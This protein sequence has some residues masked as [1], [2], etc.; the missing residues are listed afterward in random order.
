MIHERHGVSYNDLAKWGGFSGCLPVARRVLGRNADLRP[1]T[2]RLTLRLEDPLADFLGASLQTGGEIVLQV[3]DF[4][5]A[6]IIEHLQL[7]QP[8]FA[9]TAAYGHFGRELPDFTWE[10]T[11]RVD[12][13]RKAAGV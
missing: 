7:T 4:R 6:A 9:T 13:L 8:V 2:L 1:G 11:D 3:F 10:R 12:V 5:P